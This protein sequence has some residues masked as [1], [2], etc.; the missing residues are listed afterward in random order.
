MA[1]S[2]LAQEAI[3]C[4]ICGMP[5][6]QFCNNCQIILCINCIKSHVDSF[7]SLSHD[8]VAF[9]NRKIRLAFLECE[10]HPGQY[11]ETKCET[12]HTAIC[13]ICILSSVH[14]GHTKLELVKVVEAKKR[15]INKEIEE[16]ECKIIPKY[17]TS[18]ADIEKQISKVSTECAETEY[19]RE[20]LRSIWHQEVDTIFNKIGSFTQFIKDYKLAALKTHQTRI[21]N[22]IQETNQKV[23]IN[24]RF[25][26]STNPYEVAN[27]V[28]TMKEQGDISNN[29]DVQLP[30]LKSNIIEGSEL[31]IQYGEIQAT[32]TESSQCSLSTGMTFLSTREIS[33][34]ASVILTIPTRCKPLYRVVCVGK[35]EAFITGNGKNIT[36]I[37][38]RG[39]VLETF[40][41]ACCVMPSGIAVNCLGELLYS[42][43]D[44]RT[45]NI[46]RHGQTENFITLPKGWDPYS[47]C[48]TRS[49]DILV[50]VSC[51]DRNKIIKYK[52]QTI[53][54]NIERDE[55]GIP[56]FKKGNFTLIMAENNNGD[57][58][59]SDVN[60]DIVVVVDAIG[61]IRFRYDGTPAKRK[62]PFSPRCIVTDS[63]GQ[64]IVTDVNNFC[65]HILDQ[66]GHFLKCFD[67]HGLKVP[68]GLSVDSKGRLWVGL[69]DKGKVKVLEYL[70]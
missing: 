52:G 25:L 34:K 14:Q 3:K 42:D 50:H 16:Y 70:K 54:L 4:E 19:E 56:I 7:P 32:L 60:A 21:R 30:C 51:V 66:N 48:C 57:V 38:I 27:F 12:C 43:C 44:S 39:S 68:C 1:S 31:S 40:T 2:T 22:L 13:T 35:D 36:R 26:S 59:V 23:N 17:Q 49:G 69:L 46:V 58:C 55:K 37:D 15:D 10:F 8:I 24:K 41:T 33:N 65:I 20:R 47:L 64:I 62:K 61:S 18:N 53:A 6:Q 9:K 28:S 67:N 63:L 45:V 5:S 29:Y 11:C